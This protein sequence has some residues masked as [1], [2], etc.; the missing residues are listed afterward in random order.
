MS[1]STVTADQNVIRVALREHGVD[2]ANLTGP[3][4]LH[5]LLDITFDWLSIGVALFTLHRIGW[6]LSPAVIAWIGNRQRALGNLLHDAGHRNLARTHR[7][8]DTIAC[9]LLAPPLLNSLAVYRELH[10]R[11]HAWLGNPSADPDHI[12]NVSGPGYSWWMSYGKVLLTR[13]ALL[14]SML[15]HLHVSRTTRLQKLGI[16]GWWTC[17]LATV[18][19][20][21]GFQ[22]ALA[23]VLVWMVARITAF[24]AI[25]TFREM[26][27]HFGLVPDGIFSFT[28]DISARGI[29]RWI[30]HPRNN[31]Y[32]LTHHLMPSIPYHRLAKAHHMLE[33]IPAFASNARVCH[34]Y[35]RGP[36]SVVRD[37]ESFAPGDHRG[38]SQA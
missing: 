13:Q 33:C 12:P 35:F 19:T 31:G 28:R 17:V 36:V 27:D 34:A 38:V 20:C 5:P 9:L 22:A 24:H 26:C 18:W 25:T 10:A 32:H 6:W 29:W 3:D 23:S 30:I 8:N 1:T 7:V 37:W 11:H 2:L 21:T 15:G 16:L 4:V 14:G